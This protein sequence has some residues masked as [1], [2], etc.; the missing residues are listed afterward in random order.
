MVKADG[1]AFTK[2]S[3]GYPYTDVSGTLS[4]YNSMQKLQYPERAV[5]M[6]DKVQIDE[7]P[8]SKEESERVWKM[9]SSHKR[10]VCQY[11]ASSP[12]VLKG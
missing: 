6:S 2:T 1:R 10:R 4:L 9:D 12:R 5:V 8:S 7:I 11:Y 3:Q